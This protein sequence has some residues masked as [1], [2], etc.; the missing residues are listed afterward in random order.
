MADNVILLGAGAS[1]HAGIPMLGG[2]MDTMLRLATLG[3]WNDTVIPD[4]D[5]AILKDALAARDVLDSF[6]GRAAL[7]VW[8]LE[9]ILSVLVFSNPDLLPKMTKAIARVIE[10]TCSVQHNGSLE[11]LPE[12]RGLHGELWETLLKWS[13]AT[14]RPV[15]PI[16]TFNYDL[17][18]ER[19]LLRAITGSFG[20][21]RDFPYKTLEVDY[22]TP[23]CPNPK[24]GVEMQRWYPDNNRPFDGIVLRE[25]PEV[26]RPAGQQDLKLEILKL[27]GSL[28]FARSDDGGTSSRNNADRLVKALS[29]PL[30][31]PPIFNKATATLGNGIW[32]RALEVLRSCKNLIICGYS[33][34]ETDTYMQYFLKAALGPNKDLDRIFVFDPAF[35]RSDRV[36]DGEAL[37][38]RYGRN[39]S[40]SLQKRINFNPLRPS[41]EEDP[42]AGT[43]F[44]LLWCLENHPSTFLF[45]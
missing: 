26:R 22:A 17:V 2:F 45:G 42:N 21:T 3:K 18:L 9:D 8:N 13:H 41:K 36:K 4:E 24:F 16:L 30:I 38:G 12:S 27:H 44:H 32:D 33:L 28:N 23:A 29:D 35:F 31:L 7:D 39:F 25:A 6:H 34:P 5:R 43:L 19:S 10:L 20:S 14:S 11:Q 37:K 40:A 15:P 1:S